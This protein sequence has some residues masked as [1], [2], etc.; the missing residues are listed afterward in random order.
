MW[1]DAAEAVVAGSGQVYSA[2]VG[3]ALPANQSAALNTAFN[4]HGYHTEDGVAINYAP[5][6]T[7]H[8]AWQAKRPVR[9]DRG[10]DSF[11]LTFALLQWNDVTLVTAFG[12]GEVESLGSGNYAYHP[13]ADTDSIYEQAYVVDVIDGDNIGRFLVP[14]G[15]V[16][17]GVDSTFNDTAMANLPITI[18]ALE[19]ADGREAWTFLS[20]FDGLAAGS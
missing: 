11:R 17:E 2:P 4:G 6:I 10:T 1:N 19:P 18:E 5:E 8:G 16:V 14:R 7:R 9:I 12:G 20:N 15:V 3:T 13:P